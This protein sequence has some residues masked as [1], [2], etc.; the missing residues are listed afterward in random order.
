MTS[1][2]MLNPELSLIVPTYNERE[3][4]ASLIERVHKALSQ[5]KYELIMVD[6]NSPD[7]T[8][9]VVKSL[10]SDYPVRVIVRKNERGLASA[11]VAGFKEAK[12]D[13]L[14]VIDADLQH[15]PEAIPDLMGAINNGADIAIGSRYVE[16]GGT[17]NWGA[18]RGLISW[19]AKMLAVVLLP[20]IKKIEDPLAGFFLFK[21]EVIKDT[22]LTPVGY[23]ILLEVLVKGNA[24]HIVEVPYIF[25]GRE[26]GESNLTFREQLNYLIHL[27]RLGWYEGG[28]VRFLKFCTVGTSGFVVNLGLLALFVEVAGLGKT[29]SVGISYEISIITNFILNDYWTFRDRRTAAY[30]SFLNRG[31]KF[32]LVSLVGWGINLAVFSIFHNVVGLHYIVSAIIAVACAIFWNFISNVKWTWSAKRQENYNNMRVTGEE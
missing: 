9:D 2:N 32:N 21:R 13:V 24:R 17:E 23:K 10:S 16:G 3:N 12:A 20:S 8:S 5:Y 15:P 29:L 19:G 22:E 25:K 31:L 1:Q 6:D 11:V 14:G 30:G 18:E 28:I 7:G 4:I 27:A 26:K